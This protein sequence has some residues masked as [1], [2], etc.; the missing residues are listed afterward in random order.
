MTAIIDIISPVEMGEQR[1]SVTLD[2][3]SKPLLAFKP[4]TINFDYSNASP[5]GI[6]LPLEIEVQPDAKHIAQAG[7][8]RTK[9][10]RTIAPESYTFTV[11]SAG[12]YLVVLREIYHMQWYGKL[13]LEVDGDRLIKNSR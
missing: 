10:Y 2:E 13:L 8:Y 12:D 11:P 5:E 6:V 7:G 3:T 1:I 9:I 4:I